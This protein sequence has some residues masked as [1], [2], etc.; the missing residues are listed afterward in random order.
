MERFDVIIIGGG[1]GGTHAAQSLAA[2]GKSVAMVEDAH[3][4]GTCLNCGCIPTKMLLGAVAPKAQVKALER[5]RT[6]KGQV[7]VDY[8]AVQTRTWRFVNGTSQTLA[9]SLTGMGI[10]LFSGRGACAGKGTVLVT[11]VV[12]PTESSQDHTPIPLEAEHIILACGSRPAAFPG[13][14]PDNDC[15]LDSTALM[16]LTEVPASLIIVGGGAIGLELGD[17]FAAMGTAITL[18]E[19]AP[20][21]LPTEDADIALELRKALVKSGRTVLEGV[22]AHLLETRD[23]KA[24]LSLEDGSVHTAD[25][26]LVA[27]GRTPNTACLDAENAGCS[28][29]RRGFVEVDAHLQAAP[30]VYA[31]GDVNGITLL[32]HAAEHQGAYVAR[33]ILGQEQGAYI[34]GP[35]PSCVYGSMEVMRVGRTATDVAKAGGQPLVSTAPLSANAI[36]QAG[37]HTTGFVKA[38]WDGDTLV[39]MAAVGH[40]VSHLVTVAQLLVLGAYATPHAFMFAHPTLDEILS[41]VLRAPKAAFARA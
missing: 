3:F 24:L 11:P 32:A 19:A 41:T 39:G 10:R 16:H 9:K 2:A 4:G 31:V 12:T 23:G 21:I 35:V 17:F 14:A 7:D 33:R 1:P 6:L 13:M 22:K 26:A 30:N 37:G 29:N 20:H 40:G 34:S 25:K 8:T 38:V 5:L 28:L 36:A 27:V 15:V 18:V